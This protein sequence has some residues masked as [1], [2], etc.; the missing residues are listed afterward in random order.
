MEE[1]CMRPGE[2]PSFF[3]FLLFASRFREKRFFIL[4]FR[5]ERAF[6]FSLVALRLEREDRGETQYRF[7]LSYGRSAQPQK[8]MREIT[9]F[10]PLLYLAFGFVEGLS[11]SALK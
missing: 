5:G 3:F 2:S 7:F 6:P 4:P 9:S 10:S 8:G 11:L 1:F